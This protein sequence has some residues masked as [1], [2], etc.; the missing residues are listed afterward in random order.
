[1]Q[2][3]NSWA[4][5]HLRSIRRRPRLVA[6]VRRVISVE[7]RAVQSVFTP[8]HAVHPPALGAGDVLLAGRRLAHGMVAAEEADTG[9]APPAAQATGR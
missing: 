8:P 5:K 3:I 7:R 2:S 9:T 6:R 4:G 1:M